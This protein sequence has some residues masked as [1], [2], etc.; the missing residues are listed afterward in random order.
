MSTLHELFL[1]EI[2]Q[3]RGKFLSKAGSEFSLTEIKTLPEPVRRYLITC[4]YLSRPKQWY[5]QL[6]WTDVIMQFR[7]KGKWHKMD[8][9]QFNAVPEPVRLVHMRTK[10]AGLLPFEA[11][12]KFQHQHGNM[13]IRLLGMFTLQNARGPEM[14][15]S[16]LVT[17]LAEAL[18][19]PAY[20][21][22]PYIQWTP[23]A[24]DRAIAWMS[25]GDSVVHGIFFFNGQGEFVRF[26]TRH[27][28]Q[29]KKHGRFEKKPWRI[30]AADYITTNGIKHPSRVS[31]SWREGDEWV[32]YFHGRLVW[33]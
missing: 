12:D 1:E 5:A 17:L 10:I 31:A 4:G 11:R 32:D 21:L 24:A 30:T 7:P 3:E 20:A 16:A 29:S 27:R 18:L 6:K 19:L 22:Q 2:K 14:D 25:S 9:W 15:E 23:V 8:C 26:E 13:L 28:W 33:D